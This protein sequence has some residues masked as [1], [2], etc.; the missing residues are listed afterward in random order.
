MT[1]EQY[2]SIIQ[3]LESI[4]GRLSTIERGDEPEAARRSSMSRMLIVAMVGMLILTGAVYWGFQY[5]FNNI[6]AF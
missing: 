1:S 3:K 2:N 5:V 6:L 4:E